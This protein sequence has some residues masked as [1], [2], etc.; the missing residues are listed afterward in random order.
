ME[1]W[2]QEIGSQESAIEERLFS[3]PKKTV[4]S[5]FQLGEFWCIVLLADRDDTTLRGLREVGPEI[6]STLEK[7]RTQAIRKSLIEQL[8]R[9]GIVQDLDVEPQ[10]PP[11][12]FTNS[13]TDEGIPGEDVED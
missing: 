5:P 10:L 3:I 8:R 13:T 2:W 7:V 9:N 6:R 11:E 12:W 4:S 1:I